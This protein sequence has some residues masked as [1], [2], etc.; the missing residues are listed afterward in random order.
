MGGGVVTWECIE[1]L[2]KKFLKK[3]LPR[4]SVTLVKVF[5]DCVALIL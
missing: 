4:K 1:D 2:K 3:N 5:T